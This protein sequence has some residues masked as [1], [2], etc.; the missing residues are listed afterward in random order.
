MAGVGEQGV[1]GLRVE[2]DQGEAGEAVV[3]A[4]AAQHR[5]EPPQH[6]GRGLTRLDEAQQPGLDHRLG[7]RARVAVAGHVPGGDPEASSVVAQEVVEIAAGLAG[8]HRA[9]GDLIA[10]QPR[11]L[12]GEQAELHPREQ[13]HL[14]ADAPLFDQTAHEGR[15]RLGGALRLLG[16]GDPH[17]PQD[18]EA[19]SEGRRQGEGALQ[20]AGMQ[21][22]ERRGREQ[23]RDHGGGQQHR[24]AQPPAG[25]DQ[26]SDPEGAHGPL[27]REGEEAERGEDEAAEESRRR[28]GPAA[29]QEAYGQRG[30]QRHAGGDPETVEDGAPIGP[31]GRQRH[32]G[33]RRRD[34][35]QEDRQGI[36]GEAG[37]RQPAPQ[38][39]AGE[40]PAAAA[41][42]ETP[43]AQG[44]QAGGELGIGRPQ[45]RF[46]RRPDEEDPQGLAGGA[47]EQVGN[48]PEDRLLEPSHPGRAHRNQ[49]ERGEQGAVDEIDPGPH[50]Q[51]QEDHR[52]GE[53]QGDEKKKGGE[54][55]V[56]V[57]ED[58][59][60]AGHGGLPAGG[61]LEG[62]REE[63][64]HLL[65]RRAPGKVADAPVL[66]PHKKTPFPLGPQRLA[67]RRQL[68][69]QEIGH[70]LI[71]L[72]V[73]AAERGRVGLGPFGAERP[74][75]QGEAH[76]KGL[77][78]GIARLVDGLR[79]LGEEPG[80]RPGEPGGGLLSLI[81][82]D[83]LQGAVAAGGQGDL[84]L[85]DRLEARPPDQLLKSRSKEA[86]G[87]QRA[88]PPL[89]KGA[90]GQRDT[91]GEDEK[92]RAGREERTR[93]RA[94]AGAAGRHQPSPSRRR[95]TSTVVSS[96]DRAARRC[97]RQSA[98]RISR[99]F[100]AG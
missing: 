56:G 71:P 81:G 82:V 65:P 45:Q 29:R 60:S 96:S 19:G 35:R 93:P 62:R 30:E 97:R 55:L 98:S 12:L 70:A 100:A 14:V 57:D 21:P 20:P 3:R 26:R 78:Q 51:G 75:V 11:H 79:G 23:E 10:L 32:A 37:A 5:V 31:E 50:Q 88:G 16:T 49:S 33:A 22:G 89:G 47:E 7:H 76:D 84:R 40:Q 48:E 90:Q 24:Q 77:V 66:R 64:G 4:D 73:H 72:D 13:I 68:P 67:R 39:E 17:G 41:R 2:P 38:G 34:G 27:D 8:E 28:Q 58:I 61:H 43:T 1:A 54:D 36:E 83:L 86:S 6:A 9:G 69:F 85:A 87:W 25:P 53:R 74:A 95:S 92:A 91:Q 52:R 44:V 42:P 94:A 59:A 99:T 63:D 15:R 46:T 80:A 18:Q